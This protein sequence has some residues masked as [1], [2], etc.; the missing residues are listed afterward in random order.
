MKKQSVIIIAL[1]FVLGTT[2]IRCDVVM[3]ALKGTGLLKTKSKEKPQFISLG[4]IGALEPKLSSFKKEKKKLDEGTKEFSDDIKKKIAETTQAIN[5]V[6]AQIARGSGDTEFLNRKLTLLNEIYAVLNDIK[7]VRNQLI[8]II[9]QNIKIVEEYLKDP[10]LNGY[11][12]EYRD[13]KK[14]YSFNNFLNLHQHIIDQEKRIESLE[15]QQRNVKVERENREQSAIENKEAYRKK[16][17]ALE[18]FIKSPETSPTPDFMFEFDQ[19]K[20]LKLQLDLLT[21]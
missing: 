16:K 7:S 4:V 17:K 12:K 19:Q 10:S 15:E 5:E 3:D 1:L 13:P 14:L 6:N 8:D 11:R 20:K 9:E 21:L 2:Q 18:D